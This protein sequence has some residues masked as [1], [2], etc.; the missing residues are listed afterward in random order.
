LDSKADQ[1]EPSFVQR[2][3]IF[4]HVR[5]RIAAMDLATWLPGLCALGLIGLALMFAFIAACDKV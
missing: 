3:F 1:F 4:K 2:P 5:E